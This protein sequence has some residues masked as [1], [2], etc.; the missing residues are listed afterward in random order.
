MKTAE[1]E[2]TKKTKQT[3][4]LVEGEFTSS[5]ASFLIQTLL[6]EKINF[7]KLHRLSILEGN[8]NTKTTYDSGRIS[9]LENEKKVAKEFFA[10]IRQE[11]LKLQIKGKLEITVADPAQK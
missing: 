8:C 11:G 3:I 10:K 5:E 9:E 1:L 7:H 6:D 4:R 2:V